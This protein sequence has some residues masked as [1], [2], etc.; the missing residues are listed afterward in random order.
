MTNFIFGM[1]VGFIL[2]IIVG[3]SLVVLYVKTDLWF[4]RGLKSPGPP[5]RKL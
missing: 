4:K 5:M 3:V 2:G 1:I